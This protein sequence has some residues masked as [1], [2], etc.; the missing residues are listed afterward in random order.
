MSFEYEG[1]KIAHDLCGDDWCLCVGSALII[2]DEPF[3]DDFIKELGFKS[4][5]ELNKSDFI[6]EEERGC[7]SVQSLVMIPNNPSR[8]QLMVILR[9]LNPKKSSVEIQ[10]T[11]LNVPFKKYLNMFEIMKEPTK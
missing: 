4:V 5:E 9:Y 3:V 10:R 11:Q 1:R 6:Q 7:Y 8:D 2:V